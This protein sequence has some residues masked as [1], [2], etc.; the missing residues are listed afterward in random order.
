MFLFQFGGGVC[1]S[2]VLF[3]KYTRLSVCLSCSTALNM[4][5]G[6]KL[7]AMKPGRTMAGVY[8]RR[9]TG[10]ILSRKVLWHA[11]NA[12]DTSDKKYYGFFLDSVAFEVARSRS[13]LKINLLNCLPLSEVLCAVSSVVII[14]A[15][16]HDKRG[17]T[18]RHIGMLLYSNSL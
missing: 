5:S 3:Y 10:P 4:H 17:P 16:Q 6:Y 12:T 13:A 18:S 8:G 14:S 9:E 1:V 15:V 7:N 11:K 2:D